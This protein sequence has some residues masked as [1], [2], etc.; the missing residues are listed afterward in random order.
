VPF[1][2]GAV[3]VRDAP[4]EI[5]MFEENC[6]NVA[7]VD[8]E[9][10]ERIYLE[11]ANCTN[12]AIVNFDLLSRATVSIL[13]NF[14]PNSNFTISDRQKTD[15][16]ALT[17]KYCPKM[18]DDV[19]CRGLMMPIYSE[20]FSKERFMF[21][22]VLTE[23][24][25]RTKHFLCKNESMAS[26]IDENVIECG[27]G[28]STEIIE[29]VKEAR[30][31]IDKKFDATTTVCKSIEMLRLCTVPIFEQCELSQ[32]AGTIVNSWFTDLQTQ[33]TCANI[34]YTLSAVANALV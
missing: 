21:E 13:S 24:L 5:K 34:T 11:L 33:T 19:R 27:M 12:N 1:Y 4:R 28:K 6:K 7:G 8:L 26:F 15:L 3:I 20:C 22:T 25:Q 18:D 16:V 29:C 10:N 14:N 30:R 32:T 2:C 23:I 17:Q 31:A 9:R